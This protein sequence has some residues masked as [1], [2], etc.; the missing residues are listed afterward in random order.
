MEE[1]DTAEEDINRSSSDLATSIGRPCVF[2]QM[3][4]QAPI[5]KVLGTLIFSIIFLIILLSELILQLIFNIVKVSCS[6][7]DHFSN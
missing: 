5:F 3:R 1:V 7:V 6:T 4:L 2:D